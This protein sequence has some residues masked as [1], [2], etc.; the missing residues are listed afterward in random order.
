MP[1][2]TARSLYRASL[3]YDCAI[4]ASEGSWDGCNNLLANALNLY[5][6]GQATHFAML[7]ADISADEGWVDVLYDELRRLRADLVSAVVPIKD[8][9]GVTSCGVIDPKNQWNPLKRFTMREVFELPETFDAADAGFPGYGLLHNDGCMLLD[10]A[11]P[12]FRARDE[13]GV[14][15]AS[16]DFPRQV[17]YRDG[18]YDVRAESED[19]YFS[20]MLHELGARSYITRKAKLVHVGNQV[21][22]NALPWGSYAEGDEDT[23]GRW[24]AAQ[25]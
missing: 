8:H 3:R 18:H 1:F 4:L 22:S 25:A 14:L 12:L 23:A 2:A 6:A 16:F 10:L 24:K 20:R 5:D 9:R 13:Q 17:I 19:W 11:N 15:K 21:F 7:H